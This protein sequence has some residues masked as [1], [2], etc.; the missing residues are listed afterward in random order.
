MIYWLKI[1][2]RPRT[3]G[4]H[5]LVVRWTSFSCWELTNQNSDFDVMEIWYKNFYYTKVQL[6]TGYPKI[7]LFR[8]S[9]MG[10]SV[11][12]CLAI[13]CTSQTSTTARARRRPESPFPPQSMYG[14]TGTP[15]WPAP[16]LPTLSMP[17]KVKQWRIEKISRS[18]HSSWPSCV[19]D[20]FN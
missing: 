5:L 3:F 11:R 13:P 8:S 6:Y 7:I 14:S 4:H 20:W 18:F 17:N 9:A 2:R 15:N 10:T 19:L 12:P 1:E 16:R